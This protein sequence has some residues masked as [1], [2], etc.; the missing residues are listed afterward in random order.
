[1]RQRAEQRRAT[2][3]QHPATTLAALLAEQQTQQSTSRGAA[4]KA[5]STA[6]APKKLLRGFG[7]PAAR[8]A[9]AGRRLC[10]SPRG[11]GTARPFR[12]AT[13]QG[14]G[15]PA[16]AEEAVE[17]GFG[18]YHAGEIGTGHRGHKIT[19]CLCSRQ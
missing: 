1:M 6:G 10:R 5:T 18:V 12:G 11:D 14:A 4:D 8:A 2:M 13:G 15:H 16:W 17:K 3:A 19:G 9:G 7:Q